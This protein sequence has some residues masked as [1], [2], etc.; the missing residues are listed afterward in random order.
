MVQNIGCLHGK[1]PP[2]I[3]KRWPIPELWIADDGFAFAAQSQP[4]VG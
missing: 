1:L 3:L 4:F 2:V